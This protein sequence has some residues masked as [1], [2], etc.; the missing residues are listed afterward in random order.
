MD[1]R[2]GCE[3]C[4]R[5]VPAVEVTFSRNVGMLIMRRM[6]TVTAHHC[7]GCLL[8]EFARFQG[9][10]MLLGWWGTISFFMT[11]VYTFQNLYSVVVGRGTLATSTAPARAEAAARDHARESIDAEA[12]LGR[13]KH[14]IRNRLRAG[15][16]A[17]AIAADMVEVAD[18]PLRKAQ[19]YVARLARDEARA[20]R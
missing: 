15:D 9:L 14:T 7:S 6:E 4:G 12:E 17:D 18:V 20:A 19:A 2:C 11:I 5:G 3:I 16:T 1:I 10:N 13:F 8:R